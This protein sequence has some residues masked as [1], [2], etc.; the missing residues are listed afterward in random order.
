MSS[1]HDQTPVDL[2]QS[3]VWSVLLAAL[4]F[5]LGEKSVVL[6]QLGL[7]VWDNGTSKESAVFEIA[8][9]GLAIGT[10]AVIAISVV[11]HQPARRDAVA[12]AT[13]LITATLAA[14]LTILEAIWIT[15]LKEDPNAPYDALF[16]YGLWLLLVPLPFL[17]SMMKTRSLDGRPLKMLAT[18]CLSLL[19]AAAAGIVLRNG[20]KHLLLRIFPNPEA[21]DAESAFDRLQ[22]EPDMLIMLG[23]T[24]IAATLLPL[25][26]RTWRVAYTALAPASGYAYAVVA[27]LGAKNPVEIDHYRCA[28]YAAMST[29]ALLPSVIIWPLKGW[30]T[31]VRLVMIGCL[32]ALGCGLTMFVGLALPQDISEVEMVVLSV[33][34]GLAG[35]VLFACCVLAFRLSRKHLGWDPFVP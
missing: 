17:A 18:I 33:I 31:R 8:L 14:L 12:I 32:T 5:L 4:L 24:W 11:F 9:A 23:A 29:A 28:A 6:A 30:P 27:A 13:G 21:R 1:D 35:A 10:A 25:A 16:F 7:L 19:L 2:E 22:Y 15:P 26:G 3:H 34:Q 20:S